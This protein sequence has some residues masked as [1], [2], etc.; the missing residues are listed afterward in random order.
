MPR[1]KFIPA[2]FAILASCFPAGAAECSMEHATYVEARSGAVLQFLPLPT[3]ASP[4]DNNIFTLTFPDAP[5]LLTGDVAWTNGRRTIPY[6]AIRHTCSQEDIDMERQDGT[7]LCRLWD[8]TV[9]ALLDGAADW[10]PDS[11]DP[12]PR[13]LL[14]PNFGDALIQWPGYYTVTDR[15]AWDSFKFQ[16]CTQ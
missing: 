1:T 8:G 10:I 15:P 9:Y 2:A 3:D 14:L 5:E 16:G 7:S 13:G 11:T 4:S 12:A 6:I